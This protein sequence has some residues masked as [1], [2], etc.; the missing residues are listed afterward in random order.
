MRACALADGGQVAV[1]RLS[2]LL[3]EVRDY[4]RLRTPTDWPALEWVLRDISEEPLGPRPLLPLASCAAVGG[5]PGDA[6]PVAAA[7]EA[8]FNAGGIL[9]DLQDRDRSDALWALVG[10]ARAFNFSSALLALAGELLASAPWSAE[11]Y[12]SLSRSF[13]RATMQLLAG[14]D[15]DLCGHTATVDSYWRT[16]DEK[17]GR[18]FAWACEAGAA[19]GSDDLSLRLACRDYGRHL[20]L[21]LQLLDDLQGL[22]EPVGDGDL[23]TGAITLPLLYGLEGDTHAR[24]ELERLVPRSREPLAAARIR[25]LLDELDAREL[26]VW[27]ALEERRLAIGAL[28][29]CPGDDGVTALVAYATVVFARLEDVLA[30]APEQERT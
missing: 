23:A 14:Q 2:E 19:C 3:P 29:P 10:D 18:A 28:E 22:W 15:R 1:A 16:I 26:V 9:D 17:T 24:G 11:H 4:I 12:R 21:A 27:T 6:V 5:D 30:R 25:A 8:V 7:W 20:G 13:Y